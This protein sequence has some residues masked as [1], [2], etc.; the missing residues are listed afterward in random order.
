VADAPAR[1]ATV[2]GGYADGLMRAL[3]HRG[4]LWAG[5]VP[6]PVVGRVSMDLIIADVTHLRDDPRALHI[7]GPHQSVDDLAAAAET[8]GYEILT[9][10]GPRYARRYAEGAGA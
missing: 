10:L 8:I 4:V 9:A 5:E 3:S 1:L 6:C 7:L 2:S